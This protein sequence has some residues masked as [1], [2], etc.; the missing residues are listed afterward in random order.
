MKIL[1]RL[2]T[3]RDRAGWLEVLD[4]EGA[5]LF[6]PARAA[7]RAHDALAIRHGNATRDPLLPYGDT[8]TGQYLVTGVLATGG[9]GPDPAAWG[10]EPLVL[11]QP[12]GG[13]AAIADT[14]GRFRLFIQ[15]GETL[16]ATAGGVRLTSNEQERLTRLLDTAS[17]PIRCEIIDAEIDAGAVEIGPLPATIDPPPP[18]LS[19]ATFRDV[20]GLMPP[21]AFLAA[22]RL[23]LIPE[24][25]GVGPTIYGDPG[26]GGPIGGGGDQGA[27]SDP[28][29]ATP[30]DG[31]QTTVGALPASGVD[32]APTPGADLNPS[33]QTTPTPID[34]PGVSQTSSGLLTADS[35]GAAPNNSMVSFTGNPGASTDAN[36]AYYPDA[37]I[38]M[39]YQVDTGVTTS[40]PDDEVA[41]LVTRFGQ[42][43]D[44]I[45]AGF[46]QDPSTGQWVPNPSSG[47]TATSSGGAPPT[48]PP[49]IGVG[50]IANA[51]VPPSTLTVAPSPLVNAPNSV[52]DL[53]TYARNNAGFWGSGGSQAAASPQLQADS[54]PPQFNWRDSSPAG[55]A[56]H[57]EATDVV[58]AM[59]DIGFLGAENIYS[60][61]AVNR[62]TS[63][64]TQI[65]GS[66]IRGHD[67]VD[68]VAM[69]PESPTLIAGQS[70]L[71]AGQADV[72]GDI[73]YGGGEIPQ[74]HANLGKT[75][76]T[77]NSEFN[78][79]PSAPGDAVLQPNPTPES[80]G[81]SGL[82]TTLKGAGLGAGIGG[83]LGAAV[84]LGQMLL[85][86]QSYTPEQYLKAGLSAGGYGALAGAAGSVLDSA[87]VSQIGREAAESTLGTVARGAL[88]GPVSAA[89]T[90][91][92]MA[93]DDQSHSAE[94]YEAK[95]ARSLFA[96]TLAGIA[97]TETTALVVGSEVGA[98]GVAALGIE[99]GVGAA[100]L[101]GGL[102]GSEVPI[103]GTL[104][105]AAIGIGVYY[106][107]R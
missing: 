15:G 94:D 12:I 39:R 45:N 50:Q 76:V 31:G 102:A 65:G 86:D 17:A 44:W 74:A 7:G 29:G 54:H 101:A 79:Q 27:P 41:A 19:A 98:A 73:K 71:T 9:S 2:P 103:L 77:V 48:A 23:F 70:T 78:S 80:Y 66:P 11:L 63:V 42:S 25:S 36:S 24:T 1:I 18:P 30:G 91:L 52:A 21:R 34:T 83:G 38:G 53:F 100:A 105:G 85:G 75:G 104:I 90:V 55:T 68:L 5:T 35:T 6:G 89:I 59:K 69:P 60:E 8:P 4:D 99:G 43:D 87:L 64:V 56:F 96:G 57:A 81:G 14:Y 47:P 28:G 93:L 62:T 22:P 26:G 92:Q 37:A 46:Q 88:G 20:P 67:N 95:A 51:L 72:T 84:Q 61:V 3:N 40:I 107:A 16:S 82:G 49:P 13:E 10:E 32:V 97:A 106:A 33:T 58:S